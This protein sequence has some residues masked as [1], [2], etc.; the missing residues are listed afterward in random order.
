[1]SAVAFAEVRPSVRLAALI[2][3]VAAAHPDVEPNKLAQ[4]VAEATPTDDVAA[5]YVA[6]LESVVVDKIRGQRN[7][8]L[9]SPQSRSAKVEQRQSWWNRLLAERVA[10]EG[11]WKPLGVCTVDD[12]GAVIAERQDQI[13]AIAEQVRKYGVIAAAMVKHGAATVADLPEGAVQL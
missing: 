10:V 6:A 11:V 2:R 3:E 5:F 4:L 8:T 9:N 12:L 7:A 13:A 1:M